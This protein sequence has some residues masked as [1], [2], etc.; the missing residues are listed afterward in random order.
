M[1]KVVLVNEKDKKLGLMG[2]LEAHQD[3]G[4]LHRAVSVLLYRVNGK[5]VEVLLQKRGKK[6]PLWPMFWSNTVCTHPRDGESYEACGVRRLREE[7]GIDVREIKLRFLFK[8]LY[9]SSYN[10]EL[11]EHELDGVLVGEWNGEPRLVKDEVEDC[12]WLKWEILNGSVKKKPE[13]FSVWLPRI[14]QDARI[15]NLFNRERKEVGYGR[16]YSWTFAG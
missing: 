6:K 3:G 1:E 10:E 7:M 9:R 14:V 12:M 11:S 2:K 4:H 15:Q 13:S 5:G 8:L 16:R